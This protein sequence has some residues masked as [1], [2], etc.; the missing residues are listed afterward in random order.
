MCAILGPPRNSPAATQLDNS[1]LRGC[2]D[3]RVL[4]EIVGVE[5][6]TSICVALSVDCDSWL[7]R[8]IEDVG[9]RR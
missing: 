4:S 3:V 1:L 2:K 8:K 6:G 9:P 7:T 5:Y